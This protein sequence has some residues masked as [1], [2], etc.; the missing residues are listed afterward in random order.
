MKT[1][2]KWIR[3]HKKD[4]VADKKIKEKIKQDKNKLASY[5]LSLA[6]SSDFDYFK[7][8]V[9][10]TSLSNKEIIEGYF[11]KIY[12]DMHDYWQTLTFQE[13]KKL[14]N[15]EI[16]SHIA[17]L[18]YVSRNDQ[19]EYIAFF[20]TRINN[21][22]SSE[23]ALF[24][25]KQYN[26]LR[27]NFKELVQDVQLDRDYIEA[28]FTS[29]SVIEWPYVYCKH[30][31]GV[32]DLQN[33]QFLFSF[34]QNVSSAFILSFIEAYRSNDEMSCLRLLIENQVCSEKEANKLN[35]VLQKL[36]GTR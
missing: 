2:E 5:S 9:F 15:I 24:E 1:I 14:V 17:D 31:K 21:V 4:C 22:Y 11:I 16:E 26:A 28:G 36:G 10:M 3:Q 33:K 25:L 18:K 20:D 7:S 8:E 27:F 19:K 30:N 32:Y 6:I 13:K 35:K 12:D 23:R 34:E 29:L